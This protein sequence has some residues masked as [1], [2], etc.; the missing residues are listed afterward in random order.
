MIAEAHKL[1]LC[2]LETYLC[3]HTVLCKRQDQRG[4]VVQ[5][6]AGSGEEQHT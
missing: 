5:L 2:D 3:P 1:A 6:G 4:T